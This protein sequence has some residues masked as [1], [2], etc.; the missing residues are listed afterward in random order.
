MKSDKEIKKEFKVE[1]GASP[2][3]FY[4]VEVLRAEG[5]SRDSCSLCG[6][7]FWSVDS[8]RTV[9]GDSACVGEFSVAGKKE[10]VNSLSYIQVWEKFKSHFESRGYQGVDRYPVVARWNPTVDFTIA[11]IAAFQPFVISGEVDP[12]AKRLVIPQFCLRFGD[13]DNVG[14]TGAHYTGFVMIGQ[15]QFVGHDERDLNKAFKDVFDFLITVVGV[16]KEELVLHEDAWAGGG[17]FGPCMEFFSGGLELFNQVYMMYE[18]TST[19][20]KELGIKVLDMGLGM[21]RIAWFSQGT[22]NSYEAV[23]PEVLGKFR[24]KVSLD[25]D[26]ELLSRFSVYA[27]SLNID[28]V[29][30][31]EKAWEDV[32]KKLGFVGGR[33]GLQEKVL[34]MAAAY[35]VIEHSRALLISINDGQLPSN[36][37]GGYNLRAILRRALS[38]I[39]KFKWD[40][41][42][43]EI[44]KWHALELESFYPELLSNI[45]DTLKIL[46]V[47]E[48]K[49]RMSK[50]KAAG[51]LKNISFG[52]LDSD[53]LIELYDSQG[54]TPEMVSSY[55]KENGG[56]VDVPENFYMLVSERQA[57]RES[58]KVVGAKEEQLV[59][60]SVLSALIETKVS[61][62]KN[63]STT[64]FSSR[65]VYVNDRLVVL[66][67]TYFYPKSGGQDYDTGSIAGIKVAGLFRYGKYIVHELSSAASFSVGDEVS[68]EIDFDRRK[69]L[70]QHHTSAHIVN[71]AAR[72]VLGNHINQA[73]AVKKLDRAHLDVTHY[74]SLSALQEKAIEDEANRIVKSGID[75]G[76]FFMP[77]TEAERTFGVR[78]YQGGVA[79]GKSLRIVDIDGVDV[80]ACGGTHLNNTLEALQI[81]IVS[82]SKISDGV[83]RLHYLAG[84]AA[85]D[86]MSK[87]DEVLVKACEL[88]G[89]KTSE[90]VD[91]AAALFVLWKKG[92]KAVKKK[93]PFV[94]ELSVVGSTGSDGA[95]EELDNAAIVEKVA[96]ILGTQKEHV[97]KT[98]ERFLNEAKEFESRS[99][100]FAS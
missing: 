77:R 5:Y 52:S 59:S 2:D 8:S 97:V 11:S 99:S 76:N 44:A 42:L 24:E 27:G 17:N 87:G 83:V 51:V 9:C 65:V 91:Y 46:D 62:Y 50:L 35:S 28:E 94:F 74:S 26:L 55:A 82:S 56:H 1:A 78:I 68:C 40:V 36:T 18:Q 92:K 57:A 41:S 10:G 45:D 60:E 3:S 72:T 64:E 19:G 93:K 79:P 34:P 89:C 71:A 47:E 7:N 98:I 67:E 85:A 30:D 53:K 88:L 86:Y 49:Y 37:G 80:E 63:W 38:F 100:E 95:T 43:Q 73:G 21:E 32:A 75:I 4:A 90:L 69:Q 20:R 15:H 29:D 96:G 16:P 81:V 22:A 6:M 58:K 70:S 61:Y 48:E 31:I 12:P 33:I 23:F 84:D 54:I 13:V 66:D 39:D 14:I 25:Y